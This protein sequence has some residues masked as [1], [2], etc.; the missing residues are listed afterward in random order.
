MMSEISDYR[1]LLR[2]HF[3]PLSANGE[4]YAAKLMVSILLFWKNCYHT[5]PHLAK[6]ARLCM[7]FAPTSASVEMVFSI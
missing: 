7:T 5:I 4:G 6:L 2:A 1:G 3:P